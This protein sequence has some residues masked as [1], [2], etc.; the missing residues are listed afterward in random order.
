M[1]SIYSCCLLLLTCLPAAL[2]Q[3]QAAGTSPDV[4]LTEMQTV[5]IY[6]SISID[7]PYELRERG[8]I[9]FS[10][11]TRSGTFSE[12]GALSRPHDGAT[13]F[14]R[15]GTE[16]YLAI[17]ND[18]PSIVSDDV[19]VDETLTLYLDTRG[20]IFHTSYRMVKASE[21]PGTFKVEINHM[22]DHIS[23]DFVLQEISKKAPV[24]GS[25]GT[26]ESDEAVPEKTFVQKYWIYAIPLVLVL[27]MSGGAEQ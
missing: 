21:Q 25:A 14:Y 12:S 17:F 26:G 11:S 4:L 27:V 18:P 2:A 9:T 1:F 15:I 3:D 24:G 5:T 10:P 13:D 7:R 19:P 16:D 8:S 20:K 23:P 22:S 6:D